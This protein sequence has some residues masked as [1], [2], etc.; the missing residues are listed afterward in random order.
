MVLPIFQVNTRFLYWYITVSEAAG[1]MLQPLYQIALYF[2][3]IPI[4]FQ[5]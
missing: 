3:T 1:V 2:F 4:Y 5:M